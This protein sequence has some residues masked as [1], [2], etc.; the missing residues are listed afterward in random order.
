M[1]QNSF[2]A[3]HPHIAAMTTDLSLGFWPVAF[4]DDDD[5]LPTFHAFIPVEGA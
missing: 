5:P 2:L 3:Q 1:A 4:L